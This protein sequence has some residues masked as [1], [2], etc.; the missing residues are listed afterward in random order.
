MGDSVNVRSEGWVSYTNLP[1][2]ERGPLTLANLLNADCPVP[3]PQGARE[4]GGSR[5]EWPTLDSL[6]AVKQK[7]PRRALFNSKMK[8]SA[9]VGGEPAAGVEL[10]GEALFAEEGEGALVPVAGWVVVA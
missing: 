1:R 4:D 6:T 7:G 10:G 5:R 8:N 2:G 3:L 9:L